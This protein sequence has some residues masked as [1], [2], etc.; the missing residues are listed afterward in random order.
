MD[1]VLEDDVG[2][3]GCGKDVGSGLDMNGLRGVAAL[4]LMPLLM[5]RGGGGLCTEDVD[6]NRNGCGCG[7]DGEPRD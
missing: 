1:G 3:W 2:L 7:C 6:D 4:V 5:L